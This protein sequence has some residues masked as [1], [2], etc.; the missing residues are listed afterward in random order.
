MHLL[1]V[2]KSPLEVL[3]AVCRLCIIHTHALGVFDFVFFFFQIL[4]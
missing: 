3:R 4:S 2:R 1:L